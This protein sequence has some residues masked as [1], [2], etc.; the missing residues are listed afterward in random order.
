[1][2]AI[3]AEGRSPTTGWTVSIT[4]D[5]PVITEARGTDEQAAELRSA[6]AKGLTLATP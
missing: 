6:W 3:D 4:G 5:G 1:V 2:K